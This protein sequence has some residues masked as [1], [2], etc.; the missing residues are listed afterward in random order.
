VSGQPA[1]RHLGLIGA[2]AFAAAHIDAI[3]RYWTG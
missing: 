2:L 3:L 1:S